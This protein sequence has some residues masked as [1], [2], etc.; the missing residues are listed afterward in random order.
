VR[1]GTA[2]RKRASS[3]RALPGGPA[4]TIPADMR[5]ATWIVWYFVSGSMLVFG[6][7]IIGA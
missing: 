6:G 2:R 4:V 1:L 7:L 3:I 5:E